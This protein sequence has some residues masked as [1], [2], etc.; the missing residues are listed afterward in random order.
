LTTRLPGR[1]G[2]SSFEER[3]TAPEVFER[4]QR[5]IS[6]SLDHAV[7]QHSEKHTI[8][9]GLDPTTF[10]MA[11]SIAHQKVN[12]PKNPVLDAFLHIFSMFSCGFP[13]I[14]YT[15]ITLDCL[16]IESPFQRQWIRPTESIPLGLRGR[17]NFAAG[18]IK[19]T[20]CTHPLKVGSTSSQDG[21]AV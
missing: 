4:L 13:F 21:R 3:K 1:D 9:V 7:R 12:A 18:P 11:Y 20:S 10:K 6:T 2:H 8:L 16:E 15:C 19:A 17:T 14:F 5:Q